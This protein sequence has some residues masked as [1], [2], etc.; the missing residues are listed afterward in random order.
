[1]IYRFRIPDDE[2]IQTADAE[3]NCFAVHL[4]PSVSRRC[5]TRS[6]AK[7]WVFGGPSDEPRHRLW[8]LHR[9]NLIG[10][11]LERRASPGHG[12]AEFRSLRRS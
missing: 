2:H 4:M 12:D 9:Q 10:L 6:G 11:L 8:S 7:P 5:P 1:M 3:R